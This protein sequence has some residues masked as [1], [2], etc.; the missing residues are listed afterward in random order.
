MGTHLDYANRVEVFI[1]RGEKKHLFDPQGSG[2]L[3]RVIV[4]MLHIPTFFLGY[5]L[6]APKNF[7]PFVYSKLKKNNLSRRQGRINSILKNA[8]VELNDNEIVQFAVITDALSFSN[9]MIFTNY[10]CIYQL[11]P[12][13]KTLDIS[14]PISGEVELA[15][16]GRPILSKKS[17][18]ESVNVKFG[19]EVLGALD[20]LKIPNYIEAFLL[21][22][23]DSVQIELKA[24]SSL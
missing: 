16:M 1:K 14:H 15:S 19:D 7:H 4:L 22:L 5:L 17:L 20:D 18:L 23:Y 11:L 9:G 6:F 24:K 10:R 2:F 12:S 21:E 3:G 13:K 8:K